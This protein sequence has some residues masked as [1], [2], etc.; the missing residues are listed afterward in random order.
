MRAVVAALEGLYLKQIVNMLVVLRNVSQ[1]GKSGNPAILNLVVEK[2]GEFLGANV[3]AFAEWS[4]ANVT[5]V[6]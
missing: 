6:I 2:M 3:G 5:S 1:R 4:H